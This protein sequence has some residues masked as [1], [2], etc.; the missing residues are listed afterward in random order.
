VRNRRV[1]A[2]RQTIGDERVEAPLGHVT[3]RW[4]RLVFQGRKR[5][6]P[7][8]YEAA[9][10]EEPKEGL[11][12]GDLYVVGSRRYQNFESYLLPKARREQLRGAGQ[13]RLAITGIAEDNLE[14]RRMRIGGVLVVLKNDLGNAE[15][16]D[17]DGVLRLAP[18]D[19]GV[20]EQAEQLRRRVGPGYR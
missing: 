12:S 8:C 18:L 4:R 13:T 2:R 3:E 9:P 17:K 16:V 7:G 19:K 15:G 20:P 6:N 14:S 1:S 5:I 11:R 10:F